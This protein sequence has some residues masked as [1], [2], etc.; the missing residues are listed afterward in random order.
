MIGHR[1]PGS[2]A[3]ALTCTR[4]RSCSALKCAPNRASSPGFP[5]LSVPARNFI[6]RRAARNESS[7]HKHGDFRFLFAPSKRKTEMSPDVNRLSRAS[8]R[9]PGTRCSLRRVDGSRR[10]TCFGLDK[11]DNLRI[12]LFRRKTVLSCVT[13]TLTYS[14]R[15]LD[16][17]DRRDSRYLDS[18]SR[19]AKWL[20]TRA[21]NRA[22]RA[23]CA[24]AHSSLRK[25]A[26]RLRRLLSPPPPPLPA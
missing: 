1:Y 25:R 26:G 8:A 21:F 16:E 9:S 7:L 5:R 18:Q 23:A 19:R 20:I 12:G 17:R 4:V 11:R 24:M 10:A 15:R 3:D 6:T 2:N 14:V 22:P 13:I